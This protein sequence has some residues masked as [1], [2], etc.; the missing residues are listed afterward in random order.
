[1]NQFLNQENN[2]SLDKH[3]KLTE[4]EIRQFENFKKL[5]DQ[6]IEELQDLVFALSIIL[7]NQDSYGK[8]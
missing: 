7:I 5:D 6:D 8:V 2:D 1:M 4:A 3:L